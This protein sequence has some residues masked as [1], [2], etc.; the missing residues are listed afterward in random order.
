VDGVTVRDIAFT[1]DHVGDWI[2]IRGYDSTHLTQ[3]VTVQRLVV[4]GRPLTRESPGVVVGD[5][6]AAITIVAR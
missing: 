5:H 1:G 2:L 4:D 6:T 3:N